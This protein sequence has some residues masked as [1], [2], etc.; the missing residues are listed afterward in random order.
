MY[1]DYSIADRIRLESGTNA[2]FLQEAQ[3]ESESENPHEQGAKYRDREEVG[4][5]SF[6]T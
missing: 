5:L 3:Q 6:K 2:I 4:Y 1:H